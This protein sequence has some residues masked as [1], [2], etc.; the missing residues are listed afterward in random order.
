MKIDFKDLRIQ[1]FVDPAAR[2]RREQKVRKTRARQ[3]ISVIGATNSSKYRVFSLY[4]HAAREPTSIF[5]DRIIDVYGQYQPQRCGIE[6]NALQSL[7]G[8]LAREKAE[9]V[10]EGR[11]KMFPVTQP[12]DI[13]KDFRIRSIIQPL[14]NEGRLYI[15]DDQLELLSEVKGFPTAATKDLIDALAAACALIPKTSSEH[16]QKRQV[17][18][19]A[20]YLRNKGHPEDYIRHRIM[21]LT[22]EYSN[23]RIAEDAL[24]SI[25]ERTRGNIHDPY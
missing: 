3:A 20:R 23:A 13:D 8:D 25:L 16:A 1:M 21:E 2:P 18:E 14:L 4:A 15:P 9:E 7:F 19:V 24:E 17:E 22:K 5:R 12:T 6:A 10:F 11:V